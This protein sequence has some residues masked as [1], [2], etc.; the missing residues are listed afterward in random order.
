MGI[1]STGRDGVMR[2]VTA[3]FKW[4]EGR[5]PRR[6]KTDSWK[7]GKLV[8]WSEGNDLHRLAYMESVVKDTMQSLQSLNRFL[9]SHRTTA[10]Y[11]EIDM[12][13]EEFTK[14]LIRLEALVGEAWEGVE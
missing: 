4:P 1:V 2:E 13:R 6:T 3:T 8:S 5:N 10:N 9:K 14:R 11:V 7:G 12:C